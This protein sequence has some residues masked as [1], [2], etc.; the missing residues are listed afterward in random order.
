MV[1]FGTTAIT[2][3]LAIYIAAHDIAAIC[4]GTIWEASL[5]GAGPSPLHALVC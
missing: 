1:I 5:I 2:A 4:N 3:M